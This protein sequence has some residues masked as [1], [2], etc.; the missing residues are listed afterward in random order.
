MRVLHLA[1]W[2]PNKVHSQ[3]GN[4]V[5]R[6]IEALPKQAEGTVLHVWPAD[7]S[8]SDR[9]DP[10]LGIS[11]RGLLETRFAYVSDFA[12]RRWR[13]ERGYMGLIREL[14]AEGFEPDL[15]HLHIA[16]EAA[17]PALNAAKLW[18][19]PLVVSENWTAYH[20]EHGR[21]FRAKEERAVRKV[22][23]AAALHLPVS[24]H[25]GRAMGRYAPG[26]PSRVIPN[27]VDGRFDGALGKRSAD[28]PLR[29]LH[30][31]SMVDAHK[32]IRGMIRGVG[33]AV[34]SGADVVMDCL[35][36]AGAGGREI[37]DYRNLAVSLGLG[38]RVRFLGPAA[39]DE[40]VVAMQAA[41]AFVLFSRYENL[42]CVLLE[43]W[44]TG[45]PVVATDVGGVGEHIR[46]HKDLGALL[47]AG[48]EEA[49]AEV[50]VQWGARKQKGMMPDGV[51]ITQYARA[52][53]S[54]EA[55]GQAYLEAYRSV[56]S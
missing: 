6:H 26:V 50:L 19:V 22:L 17:R 45:L 20:A 8:A 27:V 53:F 7:R 54:T 40:V 10:G 12:P 48:D 29:L 47:D 31:S 28:G 14:H 32:D 34:S 13:M 55:V 39:V 33:A 42:P 25:L 43:A 35:G 23:A 4:F 5:R 51:D 21:S 11:G 38:E 24:E 46:G 41:D 9:M 36:G 30:V 1:S 16:A 2:H 3:L 56:L 37:A 15:I 52:R 44:M 49:L 18:N